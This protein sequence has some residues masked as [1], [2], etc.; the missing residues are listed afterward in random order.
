M[1]EYLQKIKEKFAVKESQDLKEAEVFNERKKRILLVIKARWAI[2]A[3]YFLYGVLSTL[4]LVS[5]FPNSIYF[6]GFLLYGISVLVFAFYNGL[7]HY[8][9]E[10]LSR[11]KG[12]AQ[13]QMGIDV[14]FTTIII[15]YTG[16]LY[17]WF[18]AIY[19]LII[20][21][22]AFLFDRKIET[23][24]IA[25]LSGFAFG[26]L[27]IL[28]NNNIVHK[29]SLS[30]LLEQTNRSEI[31]INLKIVWVAATCIVIA[32]IAS[33][34]L[35]VIR[36]HER[37]L[38][39]KSITDGLTELNNHSYFHHR[40]KSEVERAKRYKRSFSLILMD[41]D[42][43]KKYNDSF[44]HQAGDKLLHEVANVFKHIVRKEVDTI[45]RYGGDEFAIIAPETEAEKL[46]SE[47][48]GAIVMSERIRET[49]K[50]KL[51]VTITIGV[52]S[53]PLHANDTSKI[54]RVADAALFKGKRKGK[55]C[56]IKASKKMLE[57][58]EEKPTQGYRFTG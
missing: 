30:K 26:L 19:L 10:R 47:N 49:I 43:F 13:V 57:S 16:G 7:L 55:N 17:S 34:F 42:D 56:V 24:E 53:F 32:F 9:Y 25:S 14:L 2:V 11:F 46:G 50:E 35:G 1:T 28:E 33:Y 12:L 18:W 45:Y 37:Y 20:L 5:K 21:Q 54:F 36:E 4:W 44:G 3:F 8:S 38:A 51:P 40:L 29:Y 39:Y 6:R 58:E 27:L 15:H 52:S 31:Y 48:G 23:M 41:I 22:S